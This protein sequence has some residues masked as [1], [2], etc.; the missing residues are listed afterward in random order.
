SREL[1]RTFLAVN[2]R[3]AQESDL[4]KAMGY[5]LS[6]AITLTG[7]RQGYLLVARPDG[8]QREFQSGDPGGPAG[9]AFSRAPANRAMQQRRTLT[10]EDALA[11]RELQEM[12]SIR[13][14]QVRSAICTPFRSATGAEGAIYVEHSGRAGV[15]TVHDKESLEMLADQAAIAV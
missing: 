15:F 7:G 1:F 13:N 10:G 9:Q 11:D 5:L 14:L 3:L 8:L 2:H 12:P 4:E 6:A